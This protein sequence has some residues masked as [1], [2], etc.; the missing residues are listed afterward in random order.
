M[1][2]ASAWSRGSRT[3]PT[4]T[5]HRPSNSSTSPLTCSRNRP[6]VR[7]P[8]WDRSRSGILQ[9]RRNDLR[10]IGCRKGLSGSGR[11]SQEAW[12][13]PPEQD[14][15]RAEALGHVLRKIEQNPIR[16]FQAEPPIRRLDVFQPEGVDLPCHTLIQSGSD[17]SD[18]ARHTGQTRARVDVHP[19]GAIEVLEDLRI[20]PALVR[21]LLPQ[22]CPRNSVMPHST[23]PDP[24]SS[25]R[26]PVPPSDSASRRDERQYRA[27]VAPDRQ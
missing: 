2:Q 27:V 8:A 24:R 4:A 15:I 18:G 25:A 22:S 20:A 23:R 9:S 16:C 19:G 11:N 14:V 17:G 12:S 21:G 6:P 7:P 13:A 10:H 5:T 3:H 1:H 26:L